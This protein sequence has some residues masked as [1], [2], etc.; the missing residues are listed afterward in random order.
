MQLCVLH[1]M[2]CMYMINIDH[3]VHGNARKILMT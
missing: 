3:Q 1:D 2:G